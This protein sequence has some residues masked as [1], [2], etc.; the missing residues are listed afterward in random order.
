M[1]TTYFQPKIFERMTRTMDGR[2]VRVRFA[3]AVIDGEVCGRI[4]G[5][6]EV[7]E[8]PIFN[9][10]FSIFKKKTFCLAGA[11]RKAEVVKSCYKNRKIISPFSTLEFFMSQ[12]TRAPSYPMRT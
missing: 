6:E 12:M 4:V 5:V 3:V 8:L 9:F 7:G 11:N 10:Q 2:L 1:L